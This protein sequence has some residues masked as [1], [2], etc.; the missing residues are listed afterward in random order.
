MEDLVFWAVSLVMG[1]AIIGVFFYAAISIDRWQQLTKQVE[2]STGCKY[3][4]SPKG[5]N[6]VGYF[7]CNGVIETKRIK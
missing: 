4:G 1:F 5:A 7:D 3:L 6:S 2:L